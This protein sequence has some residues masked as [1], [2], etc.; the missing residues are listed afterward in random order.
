[1][2]VK[3]INR[4]QRRRRTRAATGVPSRTAI[5]AAAATILLLAA[6]AAIA[7]A[8]RSAVPK[9]DLEA[10]ALA[11][12]AVGQIAPPFRVTTIDG[13]P[14]DSESV[15]VP[16]VLEVFATWCPHC[17]RETAA[18]NAL[19]SHLAK[20]A[21]II[22][23]SG[24]DSASDRTSPASPE[25]VRTFAQYFHVTYPIAY[26]PQ[27]SVA[28]HYLQGGFPTIVFI[29]RDKRVAAIESGEIALPRLLSD[30]KKSGAAP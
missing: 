13:R 9:S 7:I 10:P 14:F 30:A 28:A 8:N 18:M 27:L 29:G 15:R 20:S 11:P 4:A 24:S 19:Q 22:A 26:D 6:V 12:L 16:I 2:S 1:M 21:A 17:Q 23:V 5:A 3:S 25:D